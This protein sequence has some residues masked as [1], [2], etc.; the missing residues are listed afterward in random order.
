MSE[1]RPCSGH[2]SHGRMGVFGCT[3][4]GNR[5]YKDK[6]WC[7]Q[8]DPR[9]KEKK[10]KAWDEKFERGQRED[11]QKKRKA[12]KLLK[13]LGVQGGIE[14]TWKGGY[15]EA[16]VLDFDEVEKLLKELGR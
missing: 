2:T 3:K 5:K 16:I 4:P 6:W 13:R 14:Y 8:H 7:F 11:D 15:Q 12:D 10:R 1:K 9:E